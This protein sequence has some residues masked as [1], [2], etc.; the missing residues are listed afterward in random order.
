MKTYFSNVVVPKGWRRLTAGEQIHVIN[1]KWNPKIKSWVWADCYRKH[2]NSKELFIGRECNSPR[3]EKLDFELKFF[4]NYSFRSSHQY[5]SKT[6]S[7]AIILF[8]AGAERVSGSASFYLGYKRSLDNLIRTN[9]NSI[10]VEPYID[11]PITNGD[12]LFWFLLRKIE[13]RFGGGAGHDGGKN[14][15]GYMQASDLKFNW[16]E[17]ACDFHTIK[18]EF[19]SPDNPIVYGKYLN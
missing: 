10:T 12:N 19:G 4:P 2:T 13:V 3:W 5:H 15:M 16:A 6:L 1:L 8:L 17:F 14:K 11:H 7:L 18:E 9:S